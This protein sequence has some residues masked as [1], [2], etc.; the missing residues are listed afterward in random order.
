MFVNFIISLLGLLN[1]TI[2][3]LDTINGVLNMLS[4][5]GL[6]I[7]VAFPAYSY[8][9]GKGRN[10]RIFYWVVLIMYICGLVGLGI[11]LF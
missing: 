10:W 4:M 1:A 7:A 8:I 2:P 5:V 3:G 9:S 11:D 6:L